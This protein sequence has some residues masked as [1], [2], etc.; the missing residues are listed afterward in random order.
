MVIDLMEIPKKVRNFGTLKI[1]KKSTI[2]H[3]KHFLEKH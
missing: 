1:E 3:L 2:Q